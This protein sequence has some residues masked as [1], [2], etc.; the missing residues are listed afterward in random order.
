MSRGGGWKLDARREEMFGSS[1]GVEVLLTRSGSCR[2]GL[3]YSPCC[4]IPLQL[5]L[6]PVLSCPLSHCISRNKPSPFIV[7]KREDI[8]EA[9]DGE[10]VV[11]YGHDMR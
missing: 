5:G 9:D 10:D 1:R 6:A 2:S 11:S 7:A 4:K 3:R 8:A